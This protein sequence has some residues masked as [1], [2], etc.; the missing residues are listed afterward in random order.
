[1]KTTIETKTAGKIV[2]NSEYIGNKLANWGGKQQN[3]HNHLVTVTHNKK[4]YS[5]D[6]WGSMMNPE[7]ANEQENVFA[8][9]CSLSDAISAKESFE[10]FCSNFGYNEDSRTAERIY[11]ACEKTL[12]KV[13]RVFSCDIYDLINEI[14]ETYNC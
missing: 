3:Y 2:I 10:E 11:K 14:S 1:M 6:F 8:F 9:Y 7:I 12:S 13:E 4:R 5:F